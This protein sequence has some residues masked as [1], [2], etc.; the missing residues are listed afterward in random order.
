MGLGLFGGGIGAARF[1]AERGAHVTITDLNDAETLHD[2]I[3]QLADL[4]TRLVLGRHDEHDFRQADLLIVNPAVNPKDNC[5]IQIAR[6]HD[7]IITTEIQLLIEN[8]PDQTTLIGITGSAGKST[9]TAMVGH[10]LQK[11]L[12]TQVHVGGNIGGSLLTTLDAIA[13]DHIVVLEL[14][15]FM[16]EYLDAIRFRPDVAVLTT[17]TANHLDRHGTLEAYRHAKQTLLRHQ[18]PGDRAILG[19]DAHD[20]P[21]AP[22]VHT[23][24]IQATDNLQLLIP[25]R[26]NQLN[27]SLALAAARCITPEAAPQDLADFPGLPHRLQHLATHNQHHFINDSKSTTPDAAIAAITAVREHHPD[28]DLHIILGGYDKESDMNELA[29]EAVEH[30][31][32]VYCLGNTGPHIA[33]A[34]EALA[35]REGHH[36]SV[37]RCG[38][39]EQVIRKISETLH[40]SARPAVVLLS[41]GCASW[42]QYADYRARGAHF[43]ELILRYFTEV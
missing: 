30:A 4:D 31:V 39:L 26:F 9:T 28:A 43:G 29:H 20:W 3:E 6:E 34:A 17:F 35:E 37:H 8:L 13:P 24:K 32:A 2:A 18:Q 27:A 40:D 5:Y 19:P 15:S 23:Q 41:P 25:G 16:L 38:D 33:D 14:S 22:Q 11:H 1:A 42:D 21:T 10:I 12:P 7:T 36:A